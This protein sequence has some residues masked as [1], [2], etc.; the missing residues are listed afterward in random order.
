MAQFT[1][2]KGHAWL[3]DE[4]DII[5]HNVSHTRRGPICRVC[6]TIGHFEHRPPGTTSTDPS[7]PVRLF[8]GLVDAKLTP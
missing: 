8:P 1:C 3:T 4:G 7:G 5:R 2:P 6:R